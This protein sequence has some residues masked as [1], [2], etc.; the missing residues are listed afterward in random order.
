MTLFS[1]HIIRKYLFS[2]LLDTYEN[3]SILYIND[4]VRL[5]TYKG[6]REKLLAKAINEKKLEVVSPDVII[7][8]L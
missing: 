4:P 6:K 8:N 3:G 7:T 1:F 2:F 5:N